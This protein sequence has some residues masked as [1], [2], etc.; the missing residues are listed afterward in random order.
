[1]TYKSY[2][3]TAAILAGAIGATV[4]MSTVAYAAKTELKVGVAAEGVTTLDPHF[5]TNTSDRTLSSWIFGALVRFAPGSANPSTIAPDLAESWEATPDK[6]VWTFKL[7]PDVK[8]TVGYGVVTSEDV[9]FSLDKA[10]DPKR[11]A[12]ANDYSAI[13]KVEAVDARTVRITLSKHVPSLLGLLSNYSGGFIIS[14]K[15]FEERGD[16][17]KRRPVGFGPFQVE[18]ISPGQSVTLTANGDYFRGKPKLSKITYRFLNNNSARDLAFESG[19][20]DVEQ[21]QQDQRWLQRLTANPNVQVDTVEPAELNMI[22]INIT[23]PPF[24]DFRVRQALAHAVNAAQIV[25]YRGERVNRVALSAIPSNNLGF[26]P[27]PGVLEYNPAKSRALLAEA[28]FPDGL[29]VTMINSQ[30]SGLENLGQLL[31]AQFADAGITLNIQPV[32]HATYHEMIRKDLSPIVLYGAARFPIADTYLTQF[33][34]SNSAIGKATAVTNFS[35]CDVADKQIDDA[36]VETDPNKQIEL[37]KEAQKLI[38]TKVC[39][40]PT[41][42]NL[43]VWARTNKLDWGFEL[44]G[45]MPSAPLVTEQTYFKD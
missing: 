35:H 5:A 28:G 20:I 11:S 36:R 25:K 43:G 1:M 27:D 42:D 18:S 29:T 32:E 3:A 9:V 21:G 22:H 40:I 13:Q 26:N 38:V 16:E 8:W 6:M 31:Q 37:W 30:L 19:E 14:K 15:A 24:N 2:L 33:Y 45:S 10:R 44:K 41:T 12:F 23:K 7:R 34:H 17:F 4:P 39:A